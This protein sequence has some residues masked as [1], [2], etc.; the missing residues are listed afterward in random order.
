MF[1]LV[2]KLIGFLLLIVWIFWIVFE[3]FS[4]VWIFVVNCLDF[5]ELFFRVFRLFVFFLK[6]FVQVFFFSFFL[7]GPKPRKS[8]GPQGGARRVGGRKFRA[9][10]SP[11]PPHDVVVWS[12]G[13]PKATGVSHDNQRTQT[14]TF[15]LPGLQKHHQNS[16]RR[17]PERREKKEFSGGR[18]KKKSEI[19]GGPGEG[20]SVGR[21]VR[22]QQ[23]HTQQHTTTHNT[24][25]LT[26]THTQTHTHQTPH[27][28]HRT[29]QVKLDLAKVGFGQSRFWPKSV[30]A[31]VGHTTKTL[32]LAKVG[33][34]QTRSYH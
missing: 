29:Q 21:A 31:K 16:T 12:P 7:V 25:T 15:E 28:T 13:G 9:F 5:F 27:T 17:P 2:F 22:G 18:G 4:I 32:T 20:R 30:L 14:C 6:L 1:G 33:F 11:L 23:Q 24:H 26:Q 10:F 19:F 34:G 3:C 8:G